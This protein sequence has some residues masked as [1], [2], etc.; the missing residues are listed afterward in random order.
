VLTFSEVTIVGKLAGIP[1]RDSNGKVRRDTET[2]KVIRSD[3]AV[4][5]LKMKS[6][7]KLFWVF[8]VGVE[9]K[10]V[11]QSTK[12]LKMDWIDCVCWNPAILHQKLKKGEY[13]KVVGKLS[14]R[15]QVDEDGQ[16]RIVIGVEAEG[17]QKLLNERASFEPI[18]S[19]SA[20]PSGSR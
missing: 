19:G 5:E 20:L 17:V 3:D 1:A 11:D 2:D 10:Q 16:S 15:S 8:T 18:S 14:T 13:V 7:N 6:S 12:K 4:D 9:T